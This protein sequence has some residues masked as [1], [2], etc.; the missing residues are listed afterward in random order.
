MKAITVSLAILGLLY[1]IGS[2]SNEHLPSYE[3][4]RFLESLGVD[5]WNPQPWAWREYG[6]MLKAL[7]YKR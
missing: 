1:F 7:G 5:S 4:R 6:G 3:E 2:V